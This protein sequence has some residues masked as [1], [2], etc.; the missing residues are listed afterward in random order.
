MEFIGTIH[1]EIQKGTSRGN[2]EDICIIHF[3][4]KEEEIK[5]LTEGT[6]AKIIDMRKQW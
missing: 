6:L 1:F 5:K 3:D 2:S 4:G